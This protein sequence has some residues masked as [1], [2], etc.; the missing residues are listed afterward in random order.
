[1]K[2]V[3]QVVGF[4]FLGVGCVGAVLP[5]LPTTPFFIVAAFCFAKSS[6]KI[7]DWFL[8]TRLYQKYLVSYVKEKTMTLK[9]KLSILLSVTI[10][11]GIGF[12]MMDQVWIGRIFVVIVWLCHVIYFGF[13][14]KTSPDDSDSDTII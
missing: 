10:L 3:Y 6:K 4:L 11:L 14:V 8:S 12:V 5:F 9:T 1:M 7:N 2:L 13:F